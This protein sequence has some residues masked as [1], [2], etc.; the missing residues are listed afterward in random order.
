MYLELGAPPSSP[1][2]SLSLSLYP[3]PRLML[4]LSCPAVVAAAAFLFMFCCPALFCAY[5]QFEHFNVV[6][7]K[8]FL[9]LVNPTLA[10]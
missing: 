2:L 9:L 4:L 7:I 3:C 8:F 6:V 10:A 5:F 1:P